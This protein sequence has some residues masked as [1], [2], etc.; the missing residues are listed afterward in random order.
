MTRTMLKGDNAMSNEIS[1]RGFLGRVGAVG[2][3]VGATSSTLANAEAWDG[4]PNE[5]DW[6]D[7]DQVD[8]MPDPAHLLRWGRGWKVLPTGH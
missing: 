4:W 6:L 7:I 3:L 5:H 8:F 1:R 2:A